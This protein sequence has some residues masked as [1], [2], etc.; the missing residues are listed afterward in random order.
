M[1]KFLKNNKWELII[2]FIVGFLAYSIKIFS[3]SV[4]IDT[5]AL[6]TDPTGLLNSWISI[7]RWGLV[8][9]KKMFHFLPIN[10]FLTNISSFIIFF[11]SIAVWFFNFDKIY[12]KKNNRLAKLAFGLIVITAPILAEQYYFSLQSVEVSLAF[13]LLA[14]AVNFQEK[15][16]KDNKIWAIFPT[17]LFVTYAFGCYQ[18]FIP[19]YISMCVFDYIYKYDGKIDFKLI[20]KYLFIF[21]VSMILNFIIDKIFLSVYHLNRSGYLDSQIS[22]GTER[23]LVIITRIFKSIIG[24]FIGIGT[25]ETI[26]YGIIFILMAIVINKKSLKD[27]KFFYLVCLFFFSVFPFATNIIKGSNEVVRARFSVVFVT[28]FA[29]YYVLTNTDMKEIIRIAKITAVYAIVVQTIVTFS[30][31]YIGYKSYKEDVLVANKINKDLENYDTSKQII[32]IG[33]YKNLTYYSFVSSLING[34]TIGNSFFEQDAVTDYGCTY[35]ALGLM[36]T[37]GIDGYNPIPRNGA[38]KIRKEIQQEIE[39][40][41][42]EIKPYPKKGYIV[43]LDDYIIVNF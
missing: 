1:K 6:M 3:Y 2:L 36:K 37:L 18:A 10:I 26:A 11:I 4:S 42:I 15:W 23:K 19:L 35:R 12:N 20:F 29:F 40:K 5:E 16:I 34:E 13:L 33:A 41:E 28:G 27:N 30:L 43:E 22:W 39:N 9:V 8:L 31:F 24:T 25:H 38:D 21:I 17:I 32:F 7:G 14:L